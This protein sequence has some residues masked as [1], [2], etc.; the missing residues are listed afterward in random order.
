MVI[1]MKMIDDD[2]DRDDDDDGDDDGEHG[3]VMMESTACEITTSI[4]CCLMR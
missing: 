4:E 1:V 3:D 2:D